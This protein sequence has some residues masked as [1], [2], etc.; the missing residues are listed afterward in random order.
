MKPR[1]AWLVPSACALFACVAR[2]G[3]G[4]A[5]VRIELRPDMH[6]QGQGVVLGDVAQIH[7]RDLRTMQQLVS[8]RLG[9]APHAGAYVAVR[10]A[11][12]DRWMRHQRGL[13]MHD[14]EWAGA[15]DV[16]VRSTTQHVAATRREAVARDAVNGWLA[17]HATRFSIDVQPL[18]ADLQVPSGSVTVR[19]RALPVNGEPAS[20]MVVWLDVSVDDQHVRAVPVSFSV[21]AYRDA[22]VAPAPIA[23]GAVV[24]PG[25]LE[26]REVALTAAIPTRGTASAPLRTTRAIRAGEAVGPR[27]TTSASVINRG[28]WVSLRL[29]SGAIELERPVQALEDGN[30][31]ALVQVK[32][33]DDAKPIPARVVSA[34]RVEAAL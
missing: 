2:A 22:W 31:G 25:A 5:P 13:S 9:A 12:L 23:A 33:G 29:K 11:T 6:A 32:A 30:L 14:I 16:V 17:T 1:L 21:E 28:E 3:A 8:L 20:R 15:D 26:R 18:S 34:G 27:N 10:R 7:A 24:A 19:P 4:D